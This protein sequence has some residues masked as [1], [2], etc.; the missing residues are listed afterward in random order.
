MTNF[1]FFTKDIE[2]LA[3]KI[4]Q[5]EASDN[6]IFFTIDEVEERVKQWI[7]YLNSEVEENDKI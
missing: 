6:W 5:K 7:E 4:A 2:T 3:R 1:E